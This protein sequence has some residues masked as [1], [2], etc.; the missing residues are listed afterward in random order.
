MEQ[1]IRKHRGA[2]LELL[3]FCRR[4]GVRAARPRGEQ[5]EAFLITNPPHDVVGGFFD[6]QRNATVVAQ[7]ARNA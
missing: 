7:L 2:D 4:V 3:G 6:A 5:H 1:F